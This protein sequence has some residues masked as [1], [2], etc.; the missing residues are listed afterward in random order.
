MNFGYGEQTIDVSDVLE[1]L[2]VFDTP[3]LTQGPKCTEFEQ[4]ICEYTG[5]KFAVAVSNA[6]A[7][8]HISALATG[9]TNGDRAITSPNTFLASSN[10]VLYSGGKVDFAD[11]D[12]KTGCIDAKEIEKHITPETKLIIP[13]HFSGIACDMEAIHEIATKHNLTVI[14]DAAHA[15]G[16]DYKNKKIGSCEFSKATVFSFHPVKTITTG[17]G[18][19]ITTNDKEFYNK[20][21]ALRSHGTHRGQR[22][23][24][25]MR[26][27]GYNYRM[28][29]IQAALGISQLK[30]LNNFK[31]RR[32]EITNLYHQLFKDDTRFS[33][34][35]EPSYSNACF[36]LCPLLID[37][38]QVKITKEELYDKL[39][40]KGLFLQIHYI[41][42]HT[43]PY[44]KDMG[45]NW[46]DYPAAEAYYNA[47][48]SLP[49]FPTLT[50]ND[51]HKIVQ[52][53]KDLTV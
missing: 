31:Q 51:V 13:V 25:E 30:K 53:F 1:V 9:I 7:G 21:V 49:L 29:D 50:D 5:A 41:P 40:E 6:T 39:R 33:F 20:L 15:I 43:Q 47:E 35:Q 32:R 17:E 19:I 26:E 46:G 8:L 12:P 42:V 14:E 38:S 44:Y 27:L 24:Y 3:Y 22:W 16:T 48:I 28:T 36:H 45:Y 18:G 11:I 23:H 4:A 2:N 10:C 37:F 52:I 34:L